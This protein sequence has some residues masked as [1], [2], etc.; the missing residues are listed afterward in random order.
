MKLENESEIALLR[1][2][3]NNRTVD[4][5]AAG[6]TSPE[7]H[8]VAQTVFLKAIPKGYGRSKYIIR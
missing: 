8:N 7:H 1:R 5:P 6:N 2:C 4:L 3:F